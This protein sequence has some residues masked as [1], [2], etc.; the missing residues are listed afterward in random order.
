MSPR[1]REWLARLGLVA[2]ACLVTFVAAEAVARALGLAPRVPDRILR[3]TDG[4]GFGFQKRA[5]H[6]IIDCYTNQKHTRFPLDLRDPETQARLRA[7]GFGR[8]DEAVASHPYGVEF[9]YNRAGFRERELEPRRP[10]THRVV[11]IGDSFT[12]GQGVPEAATFVRKVEARLRSCDPSWEA[13]NLGVR[14]ADLPGIRKLLGDALALAPDVV[15][16]TMV[17][18]D[19]E[20]SRVIQDEWPELDDAIVVRRPGVELRPFDSVLW[21]V[22]KDR[23]ET[24]RLSRSTIGWYRSL[25][26]RA[27][28][29]GWART[30]EDLREM[31]REAAA[32]GV[33]LGVALWPLLVDLDGGYPFKEAH[34][35]VRRCCRRQSIPFI[36]LLTELQ[37]R[38]A[39]SLWVHDGDLHPNQQAHAAVSGAL[40][41]FTLELERS[42]RS[43]PGPTTAGP[44]CPPG[45]SP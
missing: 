11:F 36:D 18:N 40:S 31:R 10:G 35:A 41:D 17:L 7:Q 45:P 3:I 8:L 9:R 34:A 12:E 5:G 27:N 16:F 21:A 30:V 39:E 26:S 37:G 28:R 42:R 22:L 38:P 20:R 24:A 33:S 13:W 4:A 1:Q 44:R 6:V 19:V 2:G 32:K 23:V 14:G 29:R 15:I 25:Y 43:G